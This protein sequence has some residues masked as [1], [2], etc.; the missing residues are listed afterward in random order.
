ML[1]YFNIHVRFR[2]AIGLQSWGVNI[3]ETKKRGGLT[4]RNQKVFAANFN[5]RLEFWSRESITAFLCA[6]HAVYLLLPLYIN[7]S[8]TKKFPIE[9]LLEMMDS[10]VKRP[11]EVEYAKQNWLQHQK[12]QVWFEVRS[13]S[14]NPIVTVHKSVDDE[15]VSNWNHFG[16]DRFE[17]KKPWRSRIW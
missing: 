6:I 2:G 1:M 14:Y 4:Y 9:I 13:T 3:R 8:I 7:Q 16:N 15:N 17:H 12:T 5:L 10:N 11:G